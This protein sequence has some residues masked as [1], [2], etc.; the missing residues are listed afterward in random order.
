MSMTY[1]K[2]I[3]AVQKTDTYCLSAEHLIHRGVNIPE[4]LSAPINFALVEEL[5]VGGYSGGNCW[6]DNKPTEFSYSENYNAVRKTFNEGL[7]SILM[8][9]C[10]NIT[11]FQAMEISSKLVHEFTWTEYEY[12]GNSSNY[13]GYYLILSELYEALVKENLI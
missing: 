12:Y 10:Y 9:L 1:E 13:M 2:F 5:I 6:N 8:Y 11:H 3:E 4:D 7:D